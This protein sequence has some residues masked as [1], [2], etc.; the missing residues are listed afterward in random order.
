[1]VGILIAL[2]LA[3]AS[4][5]PATLSAGS[6]HVPLTVVSWC[7][8]AHCGAPF[9]PAAHTAVVARGAL[10]RVDFSFD[11]TSVHVAVGGAPTTVET[12]G[13]EISWRAT[14]GGGVTIQVA[15]ARGWVTY[16]TRIRL[17]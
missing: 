3:V 17:R 6:A 9:V 16:V 7:W 5:P 11:P 1:M 12:H 2:T 14:H 10:T 8:G 4:P 15:G 13:R